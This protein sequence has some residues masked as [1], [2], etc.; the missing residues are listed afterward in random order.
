M[1]ERLFKVLFCAL[2]LGLTSLPAWAIARPE[3]RVW[4]FSEKP[5][6]FASQESDKL[7][8][9]SRESAACGYDFASGV[10]KY[11]YAQDN[12]VDGS[13]PS[14]HEIAY[15]CHSV[16]GTSF[17]HSLLVI[18]PDN[19]AEY[20]NDARFQNFDSNKRRFA[21]IGAGPV[22][23][24]LT[25]AE[26]ALLTY[27]V[28]RPTDI[29]KPKEHRQVL[30]LPSR[31]G[32]NEDA[33]VKELFRLGDAY[34]KHREQ[35][36]LFPNNGWG[37]NSNSFIEGLVEVA[38]YDPLVSGADTPGLHHPVPPADFGSSELPSAVGFLLSGAVSGGGISI[39]VPI[40]L[41]GIG[42]AY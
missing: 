42:I 35:Y 13:D 37:Y 10:H 15:A 9:A 34:N 16:S 33:A 32:G 28:N 25:S 3:N 27:G 12:P 24:I 26:G 22:G 40:D 17:Y 1:A 7:I 4:G 31:Y 23:S 11:L 18:T 5:S 8:A 21:T 30:P 29:D 41:G 19:Q 36:T 20:A 39:S 38:G 6:D 2:L 14:G